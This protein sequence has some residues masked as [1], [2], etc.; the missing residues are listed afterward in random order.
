MEPDLAVYIPWGAWAA[1]WIAASAWANRTLTV[2]GG[3][4]E[5]PYR[6]FTFG[7]FILLLTAVMGG[8]GGLKLPRNAA[9]ALLFDRL[10]DFP[11]EVK[12]ALV[13]VAALGFAFCWWARLYLGRL[14]SAKI[15]RKEGHKV[16]D[17]GPYGLVRHPIYTG[18]LAAALATMLVKGSGHAILGFAMLVIGYW[19]K[20]RLE[21]RFL[22]EQLGAVDY[23][24]Y[25]NRV[26]MLVPFLGA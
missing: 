1:T 20:A 12:W 25:A 24:A 5:W 3:T 13:V 7:G 6:V 10:W 22:R 11:A 2:P 23:D 18:L 19:M 4:R 26:P 14:W 17:T 21:E 16:V 15:T 8:E 9:T